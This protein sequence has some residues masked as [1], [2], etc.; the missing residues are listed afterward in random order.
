MHLQTTFSPNL[1]LCCAYK[2]EG[3]V[4]PT[5]IALSRLAVSAMH[6][7]TPATPF[8]ADGYFAILW[9][10]AGLGHCGGVGSRLSATIPY[11]LPTTHFS[12]S[13]YNIRARYSST[14]R[15][16]Q[17]GERYRDDRARSPNLRS[18]RGT[19]LRGFATSFAGVCPIPPTPRT[20]CR[21]SST[22]WWKPIAC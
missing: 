8:L 20:S 10:T 15:D 6:T 12:L 7:A 11:P 13:S 16:G 14:A 22:N 17:A 4:F 19:A 5:P 21:K 18:R 2:Y 3:G 9:I 1:F